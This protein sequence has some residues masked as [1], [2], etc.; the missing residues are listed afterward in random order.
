MADDWLLALAESVWLLPA[1]FVLTV[2]DA[3]L[4][5]LP[6]EIAVA[7]LASLWAASG[8]PSLLAVI[9]VAATAAVVG[10][11][12]CYVIGRFVGTDRWRWQRGPRMSKA[13]H[14]VHGTFRR[15]AAVLVFT[16]RY[17]PYAR[18]AVNLTAGSTHYPY[19]WYLPLSVAAGTTWALYHGLVGAFFGMW[20]REH[21]VLAVAITIIGAIALGLTV[22]FLLGRIRRRTGTTPA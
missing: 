12:A 2:A 9:L 21:P 3:F 8:S 10:D 11:S 13:L 5:V 19:R 17:V 14:R 15:R 20:F 6:S 7:A 4:V 22:D 1:L 16:A 18:I